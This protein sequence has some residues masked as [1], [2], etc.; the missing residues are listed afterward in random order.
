LGLAKEKQCE[1]DYLEPLMRFLPKVN[2]GPPKRIIRMKKDK[3]DN[4][5]KDE[6][7]NLGP[8]DPF[9][10]RTSIH[11]IAL[12][13]LEHSE[14][15][16]EKFLDLSLPPKFY[17]LFYSESIDK[18]SGEAILLFFANCLHTS[19]DLQTRFMKGIEVIP[20]LLA[21]R[22]MDFSAHT[23]TRS[24]SALL[25]IARVPDFRRMVVGQLDLIMASVNSNLSLNER[26]E[27]FYCA[28]AL[29]VTLR[30]GACF[31]RVP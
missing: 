3:K 28:G 31:N 25:S 30:V 23:I 21:A 20:M 12:L 29:C 19:K 17:D 22:D 26:D 7:S 2:K 27:D 18:S 16:Q 1:E 10:L 5:K 24:L 8:H 11:C 13:S 9:I 4:K 14:E 6:D 15:A